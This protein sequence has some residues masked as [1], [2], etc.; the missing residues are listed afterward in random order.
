MGWMTECLFADNGTIL[1]SAR[2]GAGTIVCAY[3]PTS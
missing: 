3:I 2:S 1:A